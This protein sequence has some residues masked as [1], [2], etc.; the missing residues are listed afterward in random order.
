MRFGS[1]R[2]LRTRLMRIDCEL[3]NKKKLCG[4]CLAYGHFSRSCPKGFSCRKPGCGKKH[5]SLLHPMGSKENKEPAAKQDGIDQQP[6][7]QDQTSVGGTATT[8]A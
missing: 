1:A 2:F 5:H 8:L 6:V 7:V 4:S 3:Y